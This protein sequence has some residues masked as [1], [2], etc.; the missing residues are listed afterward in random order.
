MAQW[1]G[2]RASTAEGKG[3]IP[4]RGTKILQAAW[5]GQNKT[6]RIILKTNKQKT[7]SWFFERIN[8]IYKSG[9]AH[10]EEK[11]EDPDKQNEK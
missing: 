1:L 5:H 3:L 2:L 7:K 11:G 6:K 10:Q 4:G 8:N 9:Q